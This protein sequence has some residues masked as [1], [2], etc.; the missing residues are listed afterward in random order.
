MT[1]NFAQLNNDH[2][3]R[4]KCCEEI[5]KL[6]CDLS[7]KEKD[8]SDIDENEGSANITAIPPL[9]VSL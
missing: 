9:N 2:K 6:R 8:N 4:D 1:G 3:V 7:N 5:W